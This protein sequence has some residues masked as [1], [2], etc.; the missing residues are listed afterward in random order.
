MNGQTLARF[1]GDFP[2][3]KMP[4][5]RRTAIGTWTWACKAGSGESASKRQATNDRRNCL[6]AAR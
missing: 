1:Q 3:S 2:R 4:T 6:N 5:I